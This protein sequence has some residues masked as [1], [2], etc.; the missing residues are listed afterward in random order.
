M[1]FKRFSGALAATLLSLAT[2][3]HT[4]PLTAGAGRA[5]IQ[6]PASVFPIDGFVGVHDPLAVRV[7]LLDDG[8]QG[9]GVVVVDQT[10]ISTDSITAMKAIVSQITGVP[11]DNIIVCASHGF[12]S[13]HVFPADHTPPEMKDQSSALAQA[14]S[15]AVHDAAIAAVADRQPARAGY[16]GGTSRVGINR[17]VPTSDGWWL[18]G[19]DSGFTDPNL[20]V[21]RID[22]ASGKP[23]AVLMDLGVQSSILDFSVDGQGR[24]MVSSDLAGAATRYVE[25][26]YGDGAISLFLVGA[27]ADQAPILQA[28]RHVVKAD[29]SVTRSDVHD[30]GFA[31]VDLLGERL[32]QDAVATGDGIK[33]TDISELQ[34]IRR[35]V[36]V[37]SQTGT[38]VGPPP[39]G[40]A[41]SVA[42]LPSGPVDVP[43]VLIRIGD[44]VIVGLR[45]ELS[46]STGA[47]IRTHSP[48]AHTL[49]VTMVDGAAKYMPAADAYDRV[50]YEARS[51]RYAKGS[52]ETVATAVVDMLGQMPGAHHP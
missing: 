7:L 5:D 27:A 41:K 37:T 23:L 8:K 19:N 42:F 20:G 30:A 34:V 22:G 29:G 45:E 13:P 46:A 18:G 28:N 36:S 3:A 21:L 32:G 50:T 38:T 16:A 17:D 10:S 11:A 48:F 35:T 52:A 40:P 24:R 51:S 39:T 26:H 6:I 25:S 2:A 31:I 12:S 15:A 44:T 1:R 14:I 9:L 49:V 4:A 33:T 47:W 43:V